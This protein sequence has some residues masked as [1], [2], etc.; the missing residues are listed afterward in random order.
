MLAAAISAPPLDGFDAAI[1]FSDI[2]VIAEA[3]KRARPSSS[4]NCRA[5]L[6]VTS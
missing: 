2:L 5:G 3:A 4:V 1:L 6:R